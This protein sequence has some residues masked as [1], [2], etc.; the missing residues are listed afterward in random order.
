MFLTMPLMLLFSGCFDD[1]IF[2]AIKAEEDYIAPFDVVEDRPDRTVYFEISDS[3]SRTSDSV[4]PGDDASYVDVPNKIDLIA[5]D[6]YE[7]T[8]NNVVIDNVTKLMWTKCAFIKSGDKYVIDNTETCENEPHGFEWAEATDIYEKNGIC[9]KLD[10]GGFNDWRMATASEL[11]S[12]MNFDNACTLDSS[13]FP[14]AYEIQYT[15][16]RCQSSIF[17][18]F[19]SKYIPY[20]LYSIAAYFDSKNYFFALNFETRDK[21]RFIRCVRNNI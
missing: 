21:K 3:R 6:N 16:G 14:Y 5:H 7:G 8:G 4:F 20:E 9:D 18:T 13:V 11:F 19:T 2:D 17:W 1:A 15:E 12:I 10:Y